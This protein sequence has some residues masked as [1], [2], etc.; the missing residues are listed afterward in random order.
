M[1]M[2]MVR[3]DKQTLPKPELLTVEEVAA[4]LNVSVR[5]A[6]RLTDEGQLDSVKLGSR[7]TRWR[8]STVDR[9]IERLR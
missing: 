5:T 9:Y 4:I 8:R 3:R 2:M 1:F 6:W 7:T